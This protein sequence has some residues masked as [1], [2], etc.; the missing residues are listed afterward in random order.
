[1]DRPIRD[2]KPTS[3]TARVLAPLVLVVVVGAVFLI[4]SGSLSGDD[5]SEKS[6]GAKRDGDDRLRAERPGRGRG[7]ATTW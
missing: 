7:R 3:W 2:R 1:M 4:V 6:D 5:D